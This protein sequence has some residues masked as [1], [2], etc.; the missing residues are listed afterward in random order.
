MHQV[1]P[2]GDIPTSGS[3]RDAANPEKYGLEGLKRARWSFLRVYCM[4]IYLRI[5]VG[6]ARRIRNATGIGE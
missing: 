3:A 1:V 5:Y 4:C 6:N 2:Q